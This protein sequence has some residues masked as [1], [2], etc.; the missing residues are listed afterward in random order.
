ME[1]RSQLR[2]RPKLL[3]AARTSASIQC[4]IHKTAF[5]DPHCVG[6]IFAR[7]ALRYGGPSGSRDYSETP[8]N[9]HWETTQVCALA[10]RHCRAE[11]VP[12]AHP[13]KLTGEESIA[14]LR[15]IPEFGRPL[16]T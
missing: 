1:A 9:I 3:S 6:C 7:C 15:Q 2:H 8:L 12:Q 11:A 14:F 5:Y 4:S 10:C 13:N 16:P